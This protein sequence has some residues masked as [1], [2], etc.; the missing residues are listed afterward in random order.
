MHPTHHQCWA[1]PLRLVLLPTTSA[2]GTGFPPASAVALAPVAAAAAA[3]VV[4]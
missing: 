4:C 3:A 2:R 1:P